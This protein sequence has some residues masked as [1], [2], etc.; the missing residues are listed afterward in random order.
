M[1]DFAR[2]YPIVSKDMISR[3]HSRL[4]MQAARADEQNAVRGRVLVVEDDPSSRRALTLLL[5]LKGFE[6]C[7]A[8][9]LADAMRELNNSPEA[10][11]L[12]LMLPDGNGSDILRHV[13]RN[14]LAI[15]VAITSGA[16]NWKSMLDEGALLP[17]AFFSKPLDFDQ[18]VCWLAKA[19]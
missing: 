10:V 4:G 6:P 1:D 12:D 13:R 17:D 18:V 14:G 7:V 11:L 9:T 2:I 5:K 3:T 15:R 16:S 8:A 19:P